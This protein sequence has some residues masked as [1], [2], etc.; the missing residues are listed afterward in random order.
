MGFCVSEHI[1][2]HFI[3]AQPSGVE[4]GLQLHRDARCAAKLPAVKDA[5][6]G[7]G[8]LQADHARTEVQELAQ[9]GLEL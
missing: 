2:N 6:A 5:I 1:A 3:T 9:F 4:L 8:A 7:H